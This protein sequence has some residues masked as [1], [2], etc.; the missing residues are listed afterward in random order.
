V[1]L[2]QY[3]LLSAVNNQGEKVKYLYEKSEGTLQLYLNQAPITYQEYEKL[4]NKVH[5]QTIFLVILSVLLL[6]IVVFLV[7][8]FVLRKGKS[9]EK[10][11]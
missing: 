10:N 6:G 5:F 8:L 2:D 4:V 11:A 3:F 9:H 7:Y 1:V